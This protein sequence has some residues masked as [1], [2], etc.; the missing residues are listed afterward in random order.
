MKVTCLLSSSLCLHGHFLLPKS[1]TKKIEGFLKNFALGFRRPPLR[2]PGVAIE[3]V[4]FE[5]LAIE[6]VASETPRRQSIDNKG[7]FFTFSKGIYNIVRQ[8]L[9]SL[10]I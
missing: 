9:L 8:S 10:C 2:W 4:A 3:G 7:H 5:T 1:E 6:E